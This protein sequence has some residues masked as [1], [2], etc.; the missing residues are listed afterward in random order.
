MESAKNSE[1]LIEG[2]GF[3]F[4]FFSKNMRQYVY[5]YLPTSDSFLQYEIRKEFTQNIKNNFL[6]YISV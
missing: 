3:L 5:K 4:F 1:I 2:R 6:I